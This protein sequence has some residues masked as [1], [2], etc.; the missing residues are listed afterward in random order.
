MNVVSIGKVGGPNY[1]EKYMRPFL[2]ELYRG[3]NIGIDRT[4]AAQI[5]YSNE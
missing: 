3:L 4:R 5:M 2:R 1:W